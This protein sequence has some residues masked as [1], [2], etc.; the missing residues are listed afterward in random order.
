MPCMGH[1]FRRR[2]LTKSGFK[3]LNAQQFAVVV[4]MIALGG[5]MLSFLGGRIRN[6][7][8]SLAAA[9]TDN[10][11]WEVAQ[12]DV[13]VLVLLDAIKS[14]QLNE[15]RGQFTLD[16]IR[17]RFDIFYS[18]IDG[19]RTRELK[20]PDSS[21]RQTA[22]KLSDA[23]AVLDNF[24]PLIDG[25][26]DKLISGLDDLRKSVEDLRLQ[27]RTATL[28]YVRL[29]AQ[30][31]DTERRDRAEL[32]ERTSTVGLVLLLALSLSTIVLIRLMQT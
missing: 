10:R 20:H 19:N 9:A 15:G 30:Q 12:I 25:P 8:S 16:E 11:Q 3:S 24:V 7:L 1:P 31:S 17:K 29:F 14:F 23:Q 28:D 2:W 13:E 26:D 5:L 32:I 6:E 18:R 22:Q 4:I 21:V 27:V